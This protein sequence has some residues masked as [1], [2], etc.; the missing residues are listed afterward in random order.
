M[1]RSHLRRYYF[2]HPLPSP[3]PQPPTYSRLSPPVTH[4][5]G[6]A[7]AARSI[8]RSAPGALL[9]P[10]IGATEAISKTLLGVQNSVNPLNKKRSDDKYKTTQTRR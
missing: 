7:R 10:M 3:P 2:P 6:S 5:Y 1:T 9:R 4:R 8:I